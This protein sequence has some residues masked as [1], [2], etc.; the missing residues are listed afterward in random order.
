M[1]AEADGTA[2]LYYNGSKKFETVS[3]GCE[4]PD[5]SRLY[6]GTSGDLAL[7]HDGSNSHINS[8]TGNLTI[9]TENNHL[10]VESNSGTM[11]KFFDELAVELYYDNSKKFETEP[12]GIIVNGGGSGE[13]LVQIIGANSSS[14]TIEFG[15]T[16]DDDVAQIWYD[17]YG[18]SLNLRTSEDAE[19]KL[20]HNNS[21]KFK[22]TSEG[23]E[24]PSGGGLNVRGGT[25]NRSQ[26]TVVW[27][28][29][30]NNNDW[31]LKLEPGTGSS[32]DYGL[33]V[34]CHSSA[35]Y[36]IGVNDTSSWKFRVGGSGNCYNYNNSYGSISDVKLKENIVDANSQWNDIKALKIRNFN[37]KR[38]PDKKLLGVV[39]QEVETIAPGLV[40]EAPD[41][42]GTVDLGTTTKHVKYSVLYMKAIKALQEAM[43]KIEVLETKVAAL[44]G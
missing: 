28:D 26:D 11:A 8:S 44:G 32:T 15:D 36:A 33:H 42:E 17:H 7:W 27:I 30:Q 21:E 23:V 12:K 43:A 37:F 34:R 24:I 2:Q 1:Y 25:S 19:I 5:N 14:S 40:E 18:K 41:V 9:D 3:T 4:L 6:L 38:D 22:T 20:Y 29:K 39:A 10:I 13:G 35:S 16:D 31:C